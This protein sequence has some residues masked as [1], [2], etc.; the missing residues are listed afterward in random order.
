MPTHKD[1]FLS[2][3]ESK[4]SW[5][6]NEIKELYLECQLE[7]SYATKKEHNALAKKLEQLEQSHY[8]QIK[9]LELALYRIDQQVARIS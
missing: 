9:K 8:R 3:L 1:L 5:G 6:R 2:R 4:T 7:A